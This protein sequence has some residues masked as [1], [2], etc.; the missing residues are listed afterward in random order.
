MSIPKNL[1]F[2]ILLRWVH[3]NIWSLSQL[4]WCSLH[5]QSATLY[6]HKSTNLLY[7]ACHLLWCLLCICH[8]YWNRTHGIS[9]FLCIGRTMIV[10]NPCIYMLKPLNHVWYSFCSLAHWFRKYDYLVGLAHSYYCCL[11]YLSFQ[12]LLTHC[13]LLFSLQQSPIPQEGLY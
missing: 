4:S 5:H 7:T 3:P 6:C 10:Q 1:C 11:L 9:K 12:L 13:W 2:F 8:M